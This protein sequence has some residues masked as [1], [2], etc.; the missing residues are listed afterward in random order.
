VAVEVAGEAVRPVAA[1]AAAEE[2]V[3]VDATV[4]VG[5]DAVAGA[6]PEDAVAKRSWLSLTDTREYLSLVERR[7]RS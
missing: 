7:M 2:E 3:S 5:V 4:A 1:A 6:V